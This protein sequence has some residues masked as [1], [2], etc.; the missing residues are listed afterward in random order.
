MIKDFEESVKEYDRML[1]ESPEAAYTYMGLCFNRWKN[2]SPDNKG[3]NWLRM[4]AE[5]G[6]ADA[7]TKLGI[8]YLEGYCV[9][10]DIAIA[11]EWF[12]KAAKQGDKEA[13]R[14]LEKLETGS[15]GER[16]AENENETV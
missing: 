11:K 4:A 1:K 9:E 15:S 16:E 10:Q 13:Q 2:A 3:I 7:Q 8:C 14:E 5:R 6:Y 12:C